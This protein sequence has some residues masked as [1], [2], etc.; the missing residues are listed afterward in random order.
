M[1]LPTPD[2]QADI[3]APQ[4]VLHLVVTKLFAQALSDMLPLWLASWN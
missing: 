1:N 3:A 4:F 2:I